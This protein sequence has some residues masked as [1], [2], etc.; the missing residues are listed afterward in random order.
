VTPIG[1]LLLG[2]GIG[3]GNGLRDGCRWLCRDSLV[4]VRV[5]LR[6]GQLVATA[7]RTLQHRRGSLLTASIGDSGFGM[8]LAV[9]FAS[10]S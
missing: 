3:V 2:I 7:T 8:A 4:I 1:P 10:A 9:L 6:D 5:Q